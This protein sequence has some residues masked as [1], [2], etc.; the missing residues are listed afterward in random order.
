MR[1]IVTSQI[2]NR[3]D[4]RQLVDRHYPNRATVLRLVKC[5]QHALADA[6]ITIDCYSNRHV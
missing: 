4:I 1:R 2:S 3:I 5:T 6:A